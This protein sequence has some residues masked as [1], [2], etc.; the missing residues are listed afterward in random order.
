MK[1]VT[2]DSWVAPKPL[3]AEFTKATGYE[4]KVVASG[5]AG[6]LANSIVLTKGNPVGDVTFGIDNTFATRV[7]GSGAL[8]PYAAKLPAGADKY[9][10][11]D[12]KAAKDLTP[13]DFGDVCVN[14]DDT[15][16]TKHKV[17]PPASLDDLIKPAYKG[18]FVTPGAATSSPGMAF[19]LATIA[20]YGESGWQG[21]W[22][23]LMANGA[24]ITSGWSDAWSVDYT[25]GGGN[26]ARPIVLSY[27]SSPA[28]T[29]TKSS[30]LLNTCLRSVEYAGVLQ[31]AKNPAGAKAFIDFMLGKSFQSAL[32][33]NMY[34]FPVDPTVGLPAEWKT[35]VKVPSKPLNVDPATITAKRDGWLRQ[36][37]DVTTH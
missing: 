12:A 18:L 1:L 10:L 14:V 25:A 36:W 30:A 6:K 24:K 15:W 13:I 4:V 28:D 17:T 31:G 8:T 29:K 35:A 34:V 2:H 20:K 22:T 5:D 3:L 23:K 7:S 19:L 21:Y 11:T 26:G 32:P 16:F 9:A 33:A 37:Q 27:D